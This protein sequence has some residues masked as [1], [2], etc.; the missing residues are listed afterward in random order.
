MRANLSVEEAL[1]LVRAVALA[2]PYEKTEVLPLREALHR[3]LAEDLR[4][5]VDRP[6]QDDTAIDGYACRREDTLSASSE[7]PVRLKVVGESPAGK[8]FLGQVGP[9]EA[10]AVYTGAPIPKGADAVI[11]VE[12]TRRENGFVLLFAPAR[13]QDIRPKGDDL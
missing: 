2:R 4:S 10:V 9:G 13:P 5:L 7:A 8:P 6:D 11:R 12:E 1:D 3:V